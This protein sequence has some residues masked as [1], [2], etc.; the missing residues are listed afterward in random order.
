M[1][2]LYIPTVDRLKGRGIDTL[3][4]AT[5]HV[6]LIGRFIIGENPVRWH[7][8]RT[9]IDD[10]GRWVTAEGDPSSGLRPKTHASSLVIEVNRK[11][12]LEEAA[13][14]NGIPA[15]AFTVGQAVMAAEI[16]GMAYLDPELSFMRVSMNIGKR[17]LQAMLGSYDFVNNT[18]SST[19]QQPEYDI[20]ERYMLHHGDYSSS[21]TIGM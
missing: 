5:A 4:I 17:G 14:R 15:A 13:D 6:P 20:V 1:S 8:T 21:S 16:P 7:L 18:F 3:S 9:H 10:A 19:S 11:R 2:A 12:L